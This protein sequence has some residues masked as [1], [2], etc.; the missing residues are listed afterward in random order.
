MSTA[1]LL[2]YVMILGEG[3]HCCSCAVGDSSSH[4]AKRES[5]TWGKILHPGRG[6]WNL[7]TTGLL[8]AGQFKTISGIF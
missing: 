7:E 8:K 6:F 4:E 1:S 2:Q 5:A 3:Y